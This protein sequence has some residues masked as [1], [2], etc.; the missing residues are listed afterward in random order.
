MPHI[1]LNLGQSAPVPPRGLDAV[2]ITAYS[3]AVEW[4]IPYLA[5]AQEQY[6]ISY[7]TTR[8]SL[9]QSSPVLSSSTDIT[10]SN[11]TYDISIQDLTPNTVYYFQLLSTNMYGMTSSSIM[12][13]RTLE[14]GKYGCNEQ[15]LP[16]PP[17]PLQFH[18][19]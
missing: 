10:A 2:N 7:S 14:A 5:Y 9:T 16:P 13:F 11:I 6:T 1:K 18:L 4:V 8:E 15:L 17:P 19:K 12:M 3:A